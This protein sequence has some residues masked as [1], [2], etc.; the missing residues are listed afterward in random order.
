MQTRRKGMKAA[1]RVGGMLAVLIFAGTARAV[2]IIDDPV[3][4]DER[5]AQVVQMSNSLCWEMYRYHQ[6]DPDYA[7]AYRT[8]K[9]VWAQAGTIRDAVREGPVETEALIQQ[10]AQINENLMQVE[11]ALSRWGDGDRSQVPL[12]GGTGGRTVMVD[13]GVSVNLPLLGVQVGG[14]RYVVTDDGPPV[15]ARRRLHPNSRGSKKSLE[16]ELAAVRTAVNYLMEDSGVS[17]SP[18]APSPGNPDAKG[19]VPQPPDAALGEPVQISP[20]KPKLPAS[21]SNR[22]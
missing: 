12:A 17:V 19:P 14:P 2:D 6:Q 13:G 20:T 21:A 16:R 10:V 15:L 11:E 18:N 4:I 3:Q 22:K 1:S 8:A 9:L 5:V 7:Q